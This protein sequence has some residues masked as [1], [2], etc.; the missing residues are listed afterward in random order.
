MSQQNNIGRITV[1]ITYIYSPS[2]DLPLNIHSCA[3]K[4]N[5]VVWHHITFGQRLTFHKF[6][7]FL[8]VILFRARKIEY[9][10][11]K[12]FETQQISITY[13]YMS[14]F[15]AK[16]HSSSKSNG[17]LNTM[18]TRN[19]RNFFRACVFSVKQEIFTTDWIFDNC[20]FL[21]WLCF[22]KLIFWFYNNQSAVIEL[23]I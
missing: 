18:K 11:H 23:F 5:Q 4:S 15:N 1:N 21:H 3:T 12:T 9:F 2:I 13:Y 8:I 16:M 10:Q 22:K 19:Q 7:T 17:F 6:G 14:Y 20:N